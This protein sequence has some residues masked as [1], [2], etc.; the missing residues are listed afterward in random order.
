MAELAHIVDG[1]ISFE[2]HNLPYNLL[3]Y[4][5]WYKFTKGIWRMLKNNSHQWAVIAMK[6][7]L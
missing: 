3:G 4:I 7:K 5:F 1:E 6:T 2:P